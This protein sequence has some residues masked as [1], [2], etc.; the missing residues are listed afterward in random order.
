[1]YMK[2]QLELAITVDAM[3]DFVKAAYTL[4]GD[5]AL[6]LVAYEQLCVLY[7]AISSQHYPNVNAVAKKLSQVYMNNN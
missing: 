7:S 5:G 2:L 6:A 4:E 1:M 3:E